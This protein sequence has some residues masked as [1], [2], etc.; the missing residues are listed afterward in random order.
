M[1]ERVVLKLGASRI[2][3]SVDTEARMIVAPS[4]P[5]SSIGVEG[6]PF[7]P[8]SAVYTIR[9]AGSE[10]LE[11]TASV[12]AA[13][14]TV[15]PASGTL[16]AGQVTQIT[17]EIDSDANALTPGVS[18]GTLTVT[19]T[20]NGV[21]TTTIGAALTVTE[22]GTTTSNLTHDGE[23]ITFNSAVQVGE[24]VTGRKWFLS[25][26]EIT[27]IARAHSTNGIDGA[28]VDP[29]EARTAGHGFDASLASSGAYS[30][31]LDLTRNLPYMPVAGE[32]IV[33]VTSWV[34]GDAGAPASLRPRLRRAAAFH[35]VDS[36]PA[37]NAFAPNWAGTTK[38]EFTTDDITYANLPGAVLP[39]LSVPSGTRPPLSAV[40]NYLSKIWLD[41]H[42]SIGD[43]TQYF[44]PSENM[45]NYGRE[46]GQ[47]IGLALIYL[48]MDAATIG[49][50]TTLRN[51][52]IQMGIDYYG[53][54]TAGV[55]WINNG[56][57]N[58]WK[59]ALILAAGQLLDD[60]GML[61]IGTNYPASGN[62]FAEDAS[63]FIVSPTDVSRVLHHMVD[64]AVTSGTT[65]E[66]TGTIT[67]VAGATS[68][69]T[70]LYGYATVNGTLM[71][72]MSGTGAG[73][74]R[75]VIASS[76]VRGVHIP[77]GGSLS[78]TPDTAWSPALD[79]SSVVRLLGYPAAQKGSYDNAWEGVADWGPV[80]TA[81]SGGGPNSDNPSFEAEYRPIGFSAGSNIVLAML[82]MGLKT[83]WNHDPMFDYM[84]RHMDTIGYTGSARCSGFYRA[85]TESVWDTHRGDF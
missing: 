5:L 73:Q 35:C 65:G 68:Q 27:D 30:S 17:L 52:I 63:T 47:Q 46:H 23:T 64:I 13:W 22:G 3:V 19:N 74:I 32:A 1:P 45:P 75:R 28:M 76:Q 51:R 67:R 48:C 21:G 42:G 60:A 7:S 10:P 41:N 26:A 85:W 40:E 15:T 84:D 69:A 82:A 81:Y 83:A 9:N 72:V 80:H 16:G 38:H 57:L 66:I 77:N 12:D 56:A 49:D 36:P 37:A 43:G 39:S 59:K 18:T 11:W 50:K 61:A 6:G 44:N 33:K 29:G 70:Q 14:L 24:Y 20:T 8:S 78:V 58:Y 53:M 2:A 79:T 4:T 25:G 34:S 71:E 54:L 62:W 55:H 31:A